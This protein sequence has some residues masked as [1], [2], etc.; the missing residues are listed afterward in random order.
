MSPL[1]CLGCG[2]PLD[3]RASAAS[4]S[5]SILGD[6]VTDSFHACAA[7][8]AYTVEVY[9][10]RFAGEGESA[11]RGPLSREEGEERVRVVR[12]CAEPWDKRCRCPAH[13]AYFGDA[14]D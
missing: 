8:G 6:E 10:D 11:L 3:P 5:G 7:C 4:I 12:G 2:A 14:L 1:R 13:R 9:R